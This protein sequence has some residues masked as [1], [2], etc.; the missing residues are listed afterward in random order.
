M[1][2]MISA[3]A[4]SEYCGQ[5]CTLSVCICLAYAGWGCRGIVRRPGAVVDFDV[6]LDLDVEEEGVRAGRRC[7]GRTY[8]GGWRNS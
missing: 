8:S 3:T 6:D 7:P 4:A 2:R 5:C 1:D